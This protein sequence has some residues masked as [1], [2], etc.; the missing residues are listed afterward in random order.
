MNSFE[1][2]L[3][4]TIV[5]KKKHRTQGHKQFSSL[6]NLIHFMDT[7]YEKTKENSVCG[8]LLHGVWYG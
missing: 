1:P 2:G 8:T 6:E 5:Y 7:Y 3:V 4:T